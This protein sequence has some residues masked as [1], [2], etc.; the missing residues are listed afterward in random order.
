[1]SDHDAPVYLTA[2]GNDYET[3]E[4]TYEK[5]IALSIV[6]TAATIAVLVCMYVGLVANASFA[7]IVGGV[8]VTIA[9]IISFASSRHSILPLVVS[10][11]ITL[12]LWVLT[13]S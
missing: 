13:A 6:T 11:V 7:G 1:M 12:L 3:H 2:K 4:Y 9:T 10:V 8:L 5:T